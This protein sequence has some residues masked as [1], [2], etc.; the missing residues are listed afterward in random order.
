MKIHMVRKAMGFIFIFFTLVVS[1]Q[2][3]HPIGAKLPIIFKAINYDVFNVKLLEKIT[4]KLTDT[5]T[6][7]YTITDYR[8]AMTFKIFNSKQ[9]LIQEGGFSNALAV[10]KRYIYR[11]HPTVVDF[12]IRVEPYYEPLR[13]GIWITYKDSIIIEKKRYDRGQEIYQEGSS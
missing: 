2:R 11:F 1:A 7:Q 5:S 4:D 3:K 10:F 13:T 8:G 12:D 6:I 9:K